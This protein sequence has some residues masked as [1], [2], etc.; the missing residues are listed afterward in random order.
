MFQLVSYS[1]LKYHC[2][3]SY[4]HQSNFLS[5]YFSDHLFALPFVKGLLYLDYLV[6]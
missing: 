1:Q 6:C 3:L 4:N 5:F 2:I